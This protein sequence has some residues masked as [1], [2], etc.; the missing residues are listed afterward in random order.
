LD[1][2][3][4]IQKKHLYDML[5]RMQANENIAAVSCPPVPHNKGFLPTMQDLEYVMVELIQGS[6]NTF[7]AISL[8]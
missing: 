4:I 3:V 7:G 6:Y 8:W 2:D 1:A 5:A